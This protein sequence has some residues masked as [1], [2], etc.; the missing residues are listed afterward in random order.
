MKQKVNITIDKDLVEFADIMA[1]KDRSS[2][3]GYIN[4][5]LLIEMMEEESFNNLK[6]LNNI[7]NA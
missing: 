1:K 4:S 2:R 6:A 5:L 7:D 3:S